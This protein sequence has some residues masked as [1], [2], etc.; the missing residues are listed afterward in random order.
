MGRHTNK[1]EQLL[2]EDANALKEFTYLANQSKTT[3][4]LWDHLRIQGFRNEKF[5]QGY[6]VLAYIVRRLGLSKA[7]GSKRGRHINPLLQL[8]LADEEAKK[9]F[10]ELMNELGSAVGLYYYFEE[11]S[12]YGKKYFLSGQTI[13]NII[14]RLGFK[15][16]RGRNRK[17]V[18]YQNRYSY[19]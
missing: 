2:L 9:K 1:L 15:G 12:F 18:A 13:R 5:Y 19:R 6:Q 8:L 11:H 10:I 3:R 4:A 16:R 14:K 17:N 7:K